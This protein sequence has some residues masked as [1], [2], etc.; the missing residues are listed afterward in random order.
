MAGVGYSASSIERR[1]ENLRSRPDIKF[2]CADEF[3]RLAVSPRSLVRADEPHAFLKGLLDTKSGERFL[4]EEEK[5]FPVVG[6][7]DAVD[8][9]RYG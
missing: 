2:I 9:E 6:A 5:L 7:I 3:A 1:R 8:R 4:A